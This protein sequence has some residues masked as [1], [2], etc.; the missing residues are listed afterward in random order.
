[1]SHPS[2]S[3]PHCRALLGPCLER[4]QGWVTCPSCGGAGLPPE[5][6]TIVTRFERMPL[7]GG[8]LAPEAETDGRSKGPSRSPD[9]WTPSSPRR[10]SSPASSAPRLIATTG[11][12][13]SAFLMLIAYL[14]HSNHSLAI[15]GSLVVI[16][17][18][19]LLRIRTTSRD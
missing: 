10:R 4:W 17:L 7:T 14:E 16:S 18:L 13:V 1:M 3:C 12:V 5:R 11:L 6:V 19:V 2:Y 8:K 15:F 9:T